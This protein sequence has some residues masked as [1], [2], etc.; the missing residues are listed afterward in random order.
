MTRLTNRQFSRRE[1]VALTLAAGAGAFA[2]QRARAQHPPELITRAIPA[3]GQRL[4]VIG[5]GT[6]SFTESKRSDLRVL[7]SRL[8]ELGGSVVDTAPVYGDSEQV[9]GE[10]MAE[11][12]IRDR[13]FLAT[14]LTAAPMGVASPNIDSGV[15]GQQSLGRSLERL[16]TDHLD[17]LQVHNLLG[18]D[19]LWPLLSEWKLSKKIRYIGI[20]TSS[21]SQ[22]AEMI[23]VMRNYPVD[24]VQVDYSI[25]NRDAASG[26]L[27]AALERR[28][29]V[30]ANVP[31]GGRAGINLR[32]SQDRPLPPFAAEFGAADWPQLLLKYVVS[33]PAVTCTIAGSTRVEHL[34]DNQAAGRGPL[35]DASGRRRIEQYWDNHPA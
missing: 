4:P 24:F 31:F 15:Y 13:I 18:V 29:A 25:A 33:H 9:I 28:I 2:P 20:T 16:R 22:H 12:A 19:R 3:T 14:K 8:V 27:P 26:V 6:N 17:L 1:A 10:L 30:I 7:L 23:A 11:L 34:E 5:V 35:P 32:M 21:V